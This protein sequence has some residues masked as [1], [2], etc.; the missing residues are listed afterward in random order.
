[1]RI[2]GDAFVIHD[3]ASPS[4]AEQPDN[5]LRGFMSDS[6]RK[7]GEDGCRLVFVRAVYFH[8]FG[9]SGYNTRTSTGSILGRSHLN[10]RRPSGSVVPVASVASHRV[11]PIS[12]PVLLLAFLPD[13]S[14]FIGR[15]GFRSLPRDARYRRPRLS[16]L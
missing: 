5:P 4:D 6:L 9:S 8:R 2:A 1:M 13:Y 16:P 10:Y 14:V 3:C 7:M 15:R 11:A 12:P